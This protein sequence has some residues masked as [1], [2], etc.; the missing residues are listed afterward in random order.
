MYLTLY[1]AFHHCDS[2]T[3]LY[4]PRNG[5]GHG[6]MAVEDSVEL[7]RASLAKYM[8]ESNE[9][10]LSAIRGGEEHERGWLGV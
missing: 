3:R 2:V 7:S 9:R 5:S 10:M 1:N 8:L 4:L 6:L